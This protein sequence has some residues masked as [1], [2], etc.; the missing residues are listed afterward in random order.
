MAQRWHSVGADSP[1]MPVAEPRH[2]S[3]SPVGI[4]APPGRVPAHPPQPSPSLHYREGWACTSAQAPHGISGNAGPQ[5]HCQLP[6]T[7][8][9]C[10]GGAREAFLQTTPCLSPLRAA[11]AGAG[12]PS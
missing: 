11:N 8:F 7:P 10:K 6:N 12:S 1:E 4:R 5:G 3:P 2:G 9:V